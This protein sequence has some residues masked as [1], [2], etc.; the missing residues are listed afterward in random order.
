MKR[1]DGRRQVLGTLWL[2]QQPLGYH[3]RHS[4]G[5]RGNHGCFGDHGFEQY[6]PKAFLHTGQAEHI[7][8]AIFMGQCFRA[9]VPKPSHGIAQL[10]RA[11]LAFKS[12]ALGPISGNANLEAWN[13]EV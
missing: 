7:G 11:P 4:G 6:N 12:S 3:F 5:A 8:A 1:L 10:Q 2:G 13:P 9:Q